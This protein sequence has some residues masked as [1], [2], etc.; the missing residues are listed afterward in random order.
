VRKQKEDCPKVYL[1][2]ET[3]VMHT[4]TIAMTFMGE[5]FLMRLITP[6]V[7]VDVIMESCHTKDINTRAYLIQLRHQV[8]HTVLIILV[9]IVVPMS[10]QIRLH[11]FIS[12]TTIY[13]DP[14]KDKIVALQVHSTLQPLNSHYM[15]VKQILMI[16]GIGLLQ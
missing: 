2:G 14:I 12:N 13:T 3:I 9:T 5:G 1:T 7:M 6:G 15:A 10:Q 4:N 16:R 8:V 11:V